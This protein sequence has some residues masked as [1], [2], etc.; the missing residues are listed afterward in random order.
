MLVLVTCELSAENN[1]HMHKNGKTLNPAT[2]KIRKP[3]PVLILRDEL[4]SIRAPKSPLQ[5]KTFS[6]A[7]KLPFTYHPS[8]LF[9]PELLSIKA[10]S[11]QQPSFDQ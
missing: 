2:M 8:D 11:P 7:V 9:F 1:P 10:E 3:K 5:E 6:A 4:T